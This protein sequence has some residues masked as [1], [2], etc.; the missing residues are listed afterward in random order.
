M[1]KP[2]AAIEGYTPTLISVSKVRQE[3]SDTFTLEFD[4]AEKSEI[5]LFEPGQFN[6]MY[7]FGVGEVPISISGGNEKRLLHTVRN[8]GAVSAALCRAR[9]GEQVGIRGPY[10]SSWPVKNCQKKN[11]LIIAGGIGLAPL[12]G[13]IYEVL[14]NRELYG[15]V[16]LLYG[17]RSADTILYSQE[18]AQWQK[19]IQV[20]I[21]IDQAD[22]TWVGNVGVVTNLID[23]SNIDQDTIAFLC[24]PEIMMRFCLN[25]LLK[26]QMQPENIFLSLERNMKCAI[27][28]CGHCQYGPYFICKEGPVF[29]FKSISKLFT[30]KEL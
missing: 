12:R 26:K 10:G 19:K 11:L 6:M 27:G 5:G 3:L 15:H 7:A 1:T 22:E 8:V 9:V 20:N 13:V 17:A 25:K 30:I 2:H 29:R 18:L 4:L 23:K 24:G 28:L 14:K 16:T 21:T